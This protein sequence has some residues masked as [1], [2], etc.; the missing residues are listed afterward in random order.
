MAHAQEGQQTSVDNG[1][2]GD[3]ATAKVG[4][5]AEGR[6]SAGLQFRPH[7]GLPPGFQLAG[8]MDVLDERKSIYLLCLSLIHI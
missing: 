1:S 7:L 4:G 5:N 6:V 3:S 2:G 8:K